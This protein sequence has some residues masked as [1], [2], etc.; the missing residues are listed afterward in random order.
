MHCKKLFKNISKLAAVAAFALGS[1]SLASC[2]SDNNDGPDGPTIDPAEGLNGAFVVC[3]GNYG[4]ANSS[5]TYINSADNFCDNEIFR[6]ANDVPLGSQA[7]SMTV[8]GT[9]GWV[10]VCDSHVIFKISLP[11]FK[12]EGRITGIDK[13]RYIHFVSDDKAY[14]TMMNSKRIAV[15]NPKSY[16]VTGYIDLPDMYGAGDA[17]MMVQD[18]KYVY[19]NC[20]SYQN[21]L[22]RI[23]TTTDKVDASLV[24]GIQPKSM[25]MD[26]NKNLWVITD[27]GGWEQNPAGYEAP[28]LVK[29]STSDFKIVKKFELPLGANV[30]DVAVNGAGDTVYWICNGVYRMAID[31]TA[32]PAQPFLNPFPTEPFRLYGLGVSQKTGRIFVADAADYSQNGSVMIYEPDG[33]LR[34]TVAVG[35]CPRNFCFYEHK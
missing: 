11:G 27:G 9:S 17:A 24:V 6:K 15:V 8:R 4:A 33:A 28:A 1:I 16:S 20:W 23:D 5:L 7:Q 13:P 14:V 22:V 29:V 18:G 30:G 34:A 26:K 31:A 32:L 35:V 19:V 25:C 2:D 21:K 3:E 10:V 12:E